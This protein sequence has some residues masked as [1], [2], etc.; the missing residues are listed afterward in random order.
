MSV[1]HGF[2]LVKFDIAADFG[3]LIEV[4]IEKGG[5]L[6]IEERSNSGHGGDIF[7]EHKCEEIILA[8]T[9]SI[10]RGSFG[11]NGSF[12]SFLHDFGPR[13]LLN[14]ICEIISPPT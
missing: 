12:L 6:S 10:G 11:L 8:M 4:C 7:V 13:I 14:M 1:S 5:L 9:D 2:T 3:L